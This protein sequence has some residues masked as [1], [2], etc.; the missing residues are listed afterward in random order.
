MQKLFILLLVVCAF[1]ACSSG[2]REKSSGRIDTS[3]VAGPKDPYLGDAPEK[4]LGPAATEVYYYETGWG[5]KELEVTLR[6][7]STLSIVVR[8]TFKGN[9]NAKVGRWEAK[10]QPTQTKAILEAMDW[11]SV[12]ALATTTR[13]VDPTK[14]S[15]GLIVR[16]A[17]GT[18]QSFTK[19]N[20]PPYPNL[21]SG[22]AGQL[23]PLALQMVTDEKQ[24]PVESEEPL[25]Y[26]L[27]D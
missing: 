2:E 10:A 24:K 7:D 3:G 27:R 4:L 25:P 14:R 22:V 21:L 9:P 13:T 5:I 19:P 15:I 12:L 8:K 6:S 26:K 11:D 17:D 20:E 16:Y 18:E 1:L 23:K